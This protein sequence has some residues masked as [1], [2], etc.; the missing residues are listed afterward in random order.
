MLGCSKGGGGAIIPDVGDTDVEIP[1]LSPNKDTEQY[2]DTSNRY[3]WGLWLMNLNEDHTQ[4]EVVPVRDAAFHLNVTGY[5]ENPTQKIKIQNISWSQDDTLLVEIKIDHPF[6]S[7]PKWTGWDVRGIAI[8][9][10]TKTFPS[11]MTKAWNGEDASIAA[12]RALVNADG[13]TTLWNRWTSNVVQ[14]P[15]IFGYIKGK[16]AT[17][18]E[19]LIQG[20]LHGF[21]NFWTADIRHV[22]Q[23][24]EGRVVKYEFD[25]P[26]GKL[27]F[28]YAVDA[29]WCPD[30]NI[31]PDPFDIYL[32]FPVESANC[33]EPYQITAS[34][35]SNTLSKLGGS[36]TV[37]FD[38]MDWQDP[39]NFSSIHVEA[40]DLFYGIIDPSPPIGYPNATTARY[41][42]TINNDKGTAVTAG[43][44]SDL[45]IAVEDATNDGTNPDLTAYNIFKIP[46]VDDPGFWRDRLGDGSYI[47]VQLGGG[48]IEPSSLSTGQPDIAV[49]SYPE[50]DYAFFGG[51]PEI[52]LFDDDDE[53]LLVYDRELDSSFVKAG[54]PGNSPSWL[55]YPHA[56][57]A[58]LEGWFG[59]DST[60]ETTVVGNYKVKHLINIFKQSGFYGYS[61][62]SGTNGSGWLET[63]RDVTNGQGNVVGD[64]LYGLF[65]YASGATLPTSA[66]VLSVGYPYVNPSSANTYRVFIP[67]QS[68]PYVPQ[69]IRANSER[70]KCGIDTQPQPDLPD[71]EWTNMKQAFYVVESDPS[72][73]TSEVEGFNINFVN[74]PAL[75][76]W[77][78]T[79]ANIKAEFPGAYALDC[80][81]IPS[82]TNHVTLIGNQKAQYNWLCVLMRDANFWWLGFYDPLNPSP[83]NPGNNPLR[84]IFKT[85]PVPLTAGLPAPV[86]MDV[87]Q[88]YLEVYV[89]ARNP[90]DEYFASVYEYYYSLP[91]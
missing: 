79:D 47:N 70:L 58:T 76:F 71:P 77:N 59:V 65:A 11:T 56:M 5:L 66:S 53:R 73:A 25:F 50:L 13:Y 1:A 6:T 14:H 7:N 64:P 84:T 18:D 51:Q 40:P 3:L 75:P 34:I 74:L 8:L 80:E 44:G 89:L 52:M 57:D 88:R 29:S 30:T 41:Q 28:A 43:G 83:N 33:P 31:P 82:W 32:D 24:G 4:I 23:V 16:L 27:T 36:A 19:A 67:M 26:P 68:G 86:A 45:L 54:Y 85:I 49:V 37:Q 81:V 55:L 61:W 72:I 91:E 12:S 17:L 20:N 21:K 63:T 46:V 62:H 2:K 90:A 39:T 60:N 35:L 48:L 22:F 15:K 87:D 78:I 10:Y 9:N 69:A 42:V 38:V